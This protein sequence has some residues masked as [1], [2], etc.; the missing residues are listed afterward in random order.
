[1]ARYK[2]GHKKLMVLPWHKMDMVVLRGVA[3]KAIGLGGWHMMVS[4]AI[5]FFAKQLMGQYMVL[6]N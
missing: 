1:V 2:S 3:N 5:S 4:L 6:R